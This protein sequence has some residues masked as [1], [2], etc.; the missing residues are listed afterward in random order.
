MRHALVLAYYFPPIGGAGAQRPARL[1]GHLL[2]HGIRSTIV[3]G[4]GNVAGRWTPEDPDLAGE[5]PDG[6]EVRRIDV[7]EPAFPA[8]WRRRAE[9]WL[10][11]GAEWDRWWIDGVLRMGEEIRDV[12]VVYAYMSPFSTAEG[13]ARLAER[14]GVA[15]VADLGDP[16]ALDEMM[17]FP[18]GLHR[19]R[20]LAKMRRW[21]RPA[22]GVIMSTPEAVARVRSAFPEFADKPMAAIP[23]GYEATDFD[24]PVEP[25]DPDA[26]RI[27]HTGYLH[28]S[29]G[30]SQLRLKRLRRM[31]GGQIQ[32]VE[33]IT[34]SH[35]FLLDAVEKL[36]REDPSLD[37]KIE[38]HL[39]GVLTGTDREIAAASEVCRLHDYV[40]HVESTNLIRTADLL[41]LPM[42]NLPP[43]NR[44]TIVPGK[45]YEYM[46]AQRPILAAVP[47]GDIRE[48]LQRAGTASVV[49]PRDVDGMAAAILKTMEDREAGTEADVDYIA[50]FEYGALAERVS[51]FLAEVLAPAEAALTEP[52]IA[53]PLAIPRRHAAR[54]ASP[55]RVLYLAYYFPPIGGAGAQR[56]LKFARYLTDFDYQPLVVTGTGTVEGRWTPLDRSLLEELPDSVQVVR[57]AGPEPPSSVG[58]RRR[59][60]SWLSRRSAWERWW[61]SSV[62][63][64]ARNLDFDVIHASMSPYESSTTAAQLS[65]LT[66]KPWIAEFRDPWAL[67]EMLVFPTGLHRRLALSR[68]GRSLASASAI[69]MNTPE[70]AERLRSRLPS[71]SQ[72]PVV[73]IPNGFDV[74]DFGGAAPKRTDGAFRIVHAGYLHTSLGLR[75]RATAVQHRVLGGSPKGLDILSRSHVHLLAAI[76]RLR[77]R[78]PSVPVELH[79][80]GELSLVD[81]QLVRDRPYVRMHGYLSHA[82]SVSL[83]KSADLLF[84][85]M[86]DLPP[87]HRATIVPGK[88]YEYLAAA[89]P[90]LAAVPEGDARDLL[91]ASGAAKVCAPS[92]VTAMVTALEGELERWRSGRP[93]Q[94][95]SEAL[96]ARFSRARLAE[97]LATVLDHVLDS[98]ADQSHAAQPRRHPAPVLDQATT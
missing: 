10:M 50:S 41:F 1:A 89:R 39:A 24:A 12:D 42:Q 11:L 23:N 9:R 38:V 67:D 4:Q 53:A 48:I 28:T 79:L 97:D 30:K 27:V 77:E 69:V 72:I 81:I 29:L 61:T 54:L 71:L 20:E 44:A 25:G 64:A 18:T 75:Q 3:T 59:S 87:G 85:P 21:L 88:T 16:W 91:L 94:C 5:V 86:Q 32:G 46:A 73:T 7:P 83:V 14:L 68:M 76:D 37:G 60:E 6:I 62:V 96:L 93:A 82:D 66:G 52:R 63:A 2:E 43:G 36:I 65:S 90:I 15:W 47:E 51:S 74:R 22:A 45:T 78:D 70:A 33:I 95:P 58:W 31:L 49:G 17:I 8:A 40:P 80:A 55:R 92:D 98:S 84:L 35:V 26:F 19:R 57:V 34:R 56:S 13:A